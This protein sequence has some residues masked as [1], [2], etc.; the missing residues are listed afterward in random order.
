MG[1]AGFISSIVERRGFGSLE[2][3]GRVQIARASGYVEDVR[4]WT[5]MYE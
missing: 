1:Y 5:H 2:L 4:R 3:Q